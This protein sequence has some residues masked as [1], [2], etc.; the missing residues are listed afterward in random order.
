MVIQRHSYARTCA[1]RGQW[2]SAHIIKYS[3]TPTRLW[4]RLIMASGNK[5]SR[6]ESVGMKWLT[7]WKQLIGL[8]TY[9]PLIIYFPLWRRCVTKRNSFWSK[10]VKYKT[11]SPLQTDGLTS[12]DWDVKFAFFIKSVFMM[13]SF[14]HLS[15]YTNMW[16]NWIL[17]YVTR[18]I[19]KC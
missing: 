19:Q 16:W 1:K 10:W 14:C 2:R 18:K 15:W 4:F 17:L 9:V 3:F 7:H 5:T 6:Y 8:V 13:R 12:C 11:L